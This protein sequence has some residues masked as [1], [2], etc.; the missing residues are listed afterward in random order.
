MRVLESLQREPK[1]AAGVDRPCRA[2]L[3]Q[4]AERRVAMPS[5]TMTP[6]DN[7]RSDIYDL[8]AS[9]IMLAG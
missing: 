8:M 7:L 3:A 5:V 9:C 1:L 6:S 2:L 4:I